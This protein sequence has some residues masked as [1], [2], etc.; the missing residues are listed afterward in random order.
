MLVTCRPLLLCS[1]LL[2]V[3]V[4]GHWGVLSVWCYLFVGFSWLIQK[5]N[6]L[7]NT[8]TSVS[9]VYHATSGECDSEISTNNTFRPTNG[10]V[11][12]DFKEFGGTF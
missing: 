1:V 10:G 12:G 5:E 6:Y 2:F 7:T 11:Y 9:R 4:L 8:L 3:V